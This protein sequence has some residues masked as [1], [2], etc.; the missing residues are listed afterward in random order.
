MLRD[1]ARIRNAKPESTSPRTAQSGK[2]YWNFSMVLKVERD[3]A[4]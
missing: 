2:G 4:G 1:G 3:A